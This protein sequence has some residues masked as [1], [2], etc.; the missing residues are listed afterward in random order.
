MGSVAAHSGRLF[1]CAARGV[2]F[3]ISAEDSTCIWR[4]SLDPARSCSSTPACLPG[5]NLAVQAGGYLS[6]LKV[7]CHV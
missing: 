3:C 5:G 6:C 7:G 2:C 1:F 4:Q